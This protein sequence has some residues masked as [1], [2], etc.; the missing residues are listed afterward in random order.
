MIQVVDCS[1]SKRG[2]ADA[3]RALKAIGRVG[4]IPEAWGGYIF[5]YLGTM[6]GRPVFAVRKTVAYIVDGVLKEARP[7]GELW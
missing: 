7:T 1:R 4:G 5:K 6:E 2:V 3:R